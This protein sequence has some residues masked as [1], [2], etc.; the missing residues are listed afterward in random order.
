[1]NVKTKMENTLTS[2]SFL[3]ITIKTSRES[4]NE[5]SIC[6]RISIPSGEMNVGVHVWPAI[7]TTELGSKLNPEIVNKTSVLVRSITLGSTEST[8]GSSINATS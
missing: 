1:M 5:A 6:T 2:L 7:N 3:T 4:S 8:I